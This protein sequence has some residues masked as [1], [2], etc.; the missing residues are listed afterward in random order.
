MSGTF[1]TPSGM[2]KVALHMFRSVDD[3][4][5]ADA[6]SG[7]AVDGVLGAVAV[8]AAVGALGDSTGLLGS[9]GKSL[10]LN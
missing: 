6:A 1:R 9:R 4:V 2:T 8:A 3:A 7:A 10:L 5:R